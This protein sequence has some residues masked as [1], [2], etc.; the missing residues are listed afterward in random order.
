S[1]VSRRRIESKM[2]QASTR[3]R[4]VMWRRR[5]P[6]ATCSP[7]RWLG[8]RPAARRSRPVGPSHQALA[9]DGTDH[10][11]EILKPKTLAAIIE[12]AGLSVDDL[13]QAAVKR[14]DLLMTDERRYTI[15]LDPDDEE[16]GY[17]VTVP[18][19]PGVVT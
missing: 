17:T 10:S 9:G 18:A 12:Q 6:P 14:R 2:A 13:R 1:P 5:Q 8:D 16:G 11:S 19:L 3:F 4:S 7:T 15:L